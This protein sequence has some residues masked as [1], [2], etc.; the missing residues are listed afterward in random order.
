MLKDL[1]LAKFASVQNEGW[2]EN[3]SCKG[4]LLVSE[5]ENNNQEVK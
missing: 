2:V 3:E 1:V 4:S 5:S